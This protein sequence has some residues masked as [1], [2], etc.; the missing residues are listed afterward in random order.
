MMKWSLFVSMILPVHWWPVPGYYDTKLMKEVVVFCLLSCCCSYA[1]LSLTL[2]C[3]DEVVRSRREGD[4]LILKLLFEGNRKNLFVLLT[5]VCVTFVDHIRHGIDIVPVPK[6]CS[7]EIYL[8]FSVICLGDCVL[9]TINYCSVLKKVFDTIQYWR[10]GGDCVLT[11]EYHYDTNMSIPID[12]ESIVCWYWKWFIW[13]YSICYDVLGIA[14]S[15]KYIVTIIFWPWY[16]DIVDIMI[17]DGI[18]DCYHCHYSVFIVWAIISRKRKVCGGYIWINIA[19]TVRIEAVL[20]LTIDVWRRRR[21]DVRYCLLTDYIMADETDIIIGKRI[22]WLLRVVI[23][24]MQ[25]PSLE[26]KFW[27]KMGRWKVTIGLL[28]DCYYDVGD[29]AEVLFITKKWL[30]IIDTDIVMVDLENIKLLENC[31]IIMVLYDDDI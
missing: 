28:F 3:I 2:Y 14:C 19:D 6:G 10:E 7:V 20:C 15:E 13:Y 17:T 27:R 21:R 22:V 8:L 31:D 24:I 26:E 11:E 12:E 30:F 29:E 25:W 1:I 16:H 23:V 4:D 9:M 18:D 5:G